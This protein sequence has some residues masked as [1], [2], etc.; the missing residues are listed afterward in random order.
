MERLIAGYEASLNRNERN[1]Y[2]VQMMRMVS[3]EVPIYALYYNL[4]FLAHAASVRGPTIALTSDS[5]PW[6]IH[7]WHWAQ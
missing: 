1:Q 6:N 4:E 3:E 7:D 2:V 5:V